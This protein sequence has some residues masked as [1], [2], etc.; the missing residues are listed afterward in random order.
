MAVP[1][2]HIKVDTKAHLFINV[3]RILT[4]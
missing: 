2:W 3:T 1:I 4:S